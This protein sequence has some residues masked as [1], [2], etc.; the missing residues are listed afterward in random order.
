[1]M[2]AGPISGWSI[3]YAASMPQAR[4]HAVLMLRLDKQ[5]HQASPSEPILLTTASVA[6]LVAVRAEQQA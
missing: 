1:M 5:Q 4:C 3:I 2:K 6:V